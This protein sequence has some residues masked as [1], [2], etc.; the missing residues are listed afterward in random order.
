[1]LL[2]LQAGLTGKCC[3]LGTI[4]QQWRPNHSFALNSLAVKSSLILRCGISL[5]MNSN[6]TADPHF[7]WSSVIQYNINPLDLQKWKELPRKER[8]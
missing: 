2:H 8:S 6:F 1:M 7:S 5:Q 3:N 4:Q